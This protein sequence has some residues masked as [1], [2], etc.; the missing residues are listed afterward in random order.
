MKFLRN[1]LCMCVLFGV[2]VS[3]GCSKYPDG[4][5]FSLLPKKWRL[6]EDWKPKQII[7][8]G[9]DITAV[10]W[11]HVKSESRNIHKDGTFSFS[12]VN[13][14]S[15]ITYSGTWAW[16]ADKTVIYFTYSTGS[17]LITDGFVILRLKEDDMW[18]K[19]VTSS[20]DEYEFHD[21]PN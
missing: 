13:D 6:A 20:G 3:P 1:L 4:P 10:Y 7:E 9:T 16:S 17:Q 8:N 21:V 5:G 15:S 18:L 2:A 11:A 12:Q 14:N 19:Q